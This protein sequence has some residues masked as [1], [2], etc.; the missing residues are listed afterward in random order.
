MRARHIEKGRALLPL[1][2]RSRSCRRKG[3][4]T[5]RGV[6]TLFHEGSPWI[7]FVTGKRPDKPMFMTVWPALANKAR[8]KGVG[9]LREKG[10]IDKLALMKAAGLGELNIIR[11]MACIVEC[12]LAGFEDGV[13]VWCEPD[14]EIARLFI[15][16]S[17]C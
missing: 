17:K 4:A 7:E 6:E 13:Y 10:R 14:D 3:V 8:A 12:G 1:S 5:V 9:I 11:H 16:L 15:Q 2:G